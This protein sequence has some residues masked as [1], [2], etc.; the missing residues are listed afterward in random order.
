[1]NDRSPT[2]RHYTLRELL[3]PVFAMT[4]P[5]ALVLPLVAAAIGVVAAEL[6]AP[7]IP[8]DGPPDWLLNFNGTIAQIIATLVI[9]LAL[10]A[11]YV[12][13]AKWAAISTVSYVAVGLAA[14]A[15]GISPGLPHS[16]YRHL[17]ALEI[18]GGLGALIAVVVTAGRA[19]SR[20]IDQQRK[21]DQDRVLPAPPNPGR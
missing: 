10:E 5:Y 3:G 1:M 2:P 19:I 7:A 9:A 17:F 13:M 4:V 21:Q 15:A 16:T 18:G 20:E 11:R 8:K 6:A 12:Y 14:A